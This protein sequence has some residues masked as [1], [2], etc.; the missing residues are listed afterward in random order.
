VGQVTGQYTPAGSRVAYEYDVT[1]TRHAA[2]FV[3]NATVTA[4][5]LLVLRPSGITRLNSSG[6]TEAFSSPELLVRR[7]VESAIQEIAVKARVADE[8]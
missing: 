5:G 4:G 3:W 8:E 7:S 2:G 1:W 6:I